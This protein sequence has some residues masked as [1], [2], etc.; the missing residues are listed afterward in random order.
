MR[1]RVRFDGDDEGA[2]AMRVEDLGSLGVSALASQ[3]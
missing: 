3:R 2:A 1:V